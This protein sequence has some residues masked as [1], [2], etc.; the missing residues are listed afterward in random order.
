VLSRFFTELRE[1]RL[2][3]VRTRAG[4]VLCPPA[5]ADPETGAA[6][7]DA[8]VEVGP[9]GVVTTWCWVSRPRA[10]QPLARPF[11]YALIRLEGADTSLLHA[12][13]VGDPSRMRT[14]LRVR[15]RWRSE[16]VGEIADIECF[17]PERSEGG[18]RARGRAAGEPDRSGP[19]EVR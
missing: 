13:D 14:G 15:P 7:G 9:V 12:V 8:F 2:V 16:T 3:G 10:K 4:R 5:E 1:R 6:V 17:E 11:A 18:H 19:G